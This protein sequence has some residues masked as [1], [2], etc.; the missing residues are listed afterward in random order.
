MLGMDCQ[1]FAPS[2]NGQRAASC[3]PRK[4]S[5]DKYL[6][7]LH[8]SAANEAPAQVIPIENAQECEQKL[9]V[10]SV[11]F[12]PIE[13][14]YQTWGNPNGIP[15][16]FVHGG[17]GQ[18]VGDYENMNGKFFDSS[19]YFVVEVDQRGTGKS[20]PSVRDDPANMALYRDIDLAQMSQDF[21]LLRK[22]LGISQWLVFGGSWGSTLGLDYA[23][24]YPTSCLGLIARGIFLATAKEMDAVYTRNGIQKLPPT[25][26]RRNVKNF[27]TFW[28]VANQEY[29]KLLLQS[30]TD[31][32]AKKLLSS[33]VAKGKRN[34]LFEKDDY[35]SGQFPIVLDPNNS[36]GM[37]KLYERL[38]VAGDREATWKFYVFEYNLMEE[39]ESKLLDFE[40]IDES[41]YEEA[42]S[43][44]FFE[45]R[46][47]LKSVYESEVDLLG[48]V[49]SLADVPTWIVQGRSDAVCPDKFARDLEA[50]L[51]RL[52]GVLK[53]SYFLANAGHKASSTRISDTLI[54]MVDEFH[55]FYTASEK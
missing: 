46:L 45:A 12:V 30:A 36:Y 19:K 16:L 50:E 25:P 42:R 7:S 53:G 35:S 5:T 31:E 38:I 18:C 33:I 27:L 39:D 48:S 22:H 55:S 34:E 1:A 41:L 51:Q 8:V 28:K 40:V 20:T 44:S 15:V 2:N 54:K 37:L 13:I 49:S 11:D 52:G 9:V 10:D 3:T 47:F 32:D 23:E 26:D 21:E 43:V 24:R 29:E 4:S 17:P 6:Q 14:W